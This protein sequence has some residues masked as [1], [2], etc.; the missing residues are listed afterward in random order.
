MN[1]TLT[2]ILIFHCIHYISWTRN[3]GFLIFNFVLWRHTCTGAVVYLMGDHSF[4]NALNAFI[5]RL[6]KK[7]LFCM[8][9]LVNSFCPCTVII[10]FATIWEEVTLLCFSSQNQFQEDLLGLPVTCCSSEHHWFHSQTECG[11]HFYWKT[12]SVP[13]KNVKPSH[14]Y[15]ASYSPALHQDV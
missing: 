12:Q 6:I 8:C 4:H 3:K 10:S 2:L 9:L 15:M 7:N 1:V 14:Q 13:L 11:S 5:T